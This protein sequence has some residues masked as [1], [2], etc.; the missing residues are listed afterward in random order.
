MPH[1]VSKGNGLQILLETLKIEPEECACAGDAFNDVSMMMLVQHS[2]AMSHSYPEVKKA[3]RYEVE[4]VADAI[5]YLWDVEHL[6]KVA[7]K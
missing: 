1:N 6:R 4:T 3:A 2:F 5:D 7:C